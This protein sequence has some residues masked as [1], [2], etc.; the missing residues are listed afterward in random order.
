MAITKT[1]LIE[2]LKPGMIVADNTYTDNNQLVIQ[3]NTQL[4]QEIIRK[5]TYYSVKSVK[6]QIPNAPFSQKVSTDSFPSDDIRSSNT[7]PP[8]FERVQNSPEFKEFQAEFANS[9]NNFQDKL[10]DIVIKNTT[11]VVDAMLTDVENI[12]NKSRN[13]LH[14]LDMMQCMRGFDDQTYTHSLNV[15]L[16]CHVIGDWLNFSE[17]DLTILTTCGMLHDIGKLKIPAEI[18]TKPGKLTDEEFKLIQSHPQFG[19]DILKDKALD[20]RIKKAALQHHERFN[21]KGY[22]CKLTAADIDYFS[23]IVTIADVYDAMTADRCYRK[24]I[25][26]F[27]VIAHLEKERELYEPGVLYLF[28]KRT[29]EAYINTEVLLSNGEQGKVVL[30]NNNLPSRPIVMTANGIRDLSRESQLR[31]TELL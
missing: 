29:A 15:S 20:P 8:Y 12:L 28:M 19:Y 16:I 7:E 21:G 4:T 18:I 9:L 5:L 25:C 27:E 6:I 26:P 23:A 14:L 2:N 24:G 30:L 3:K 11:D 1:I 13:P 31:I 17:D 22:P 10:N